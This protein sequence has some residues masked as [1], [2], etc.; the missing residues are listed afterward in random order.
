LGGRGGEAQ[1]ETFAGR[2]KHA[3]R[4]QI[5]P[6]LVILLE[7]LAIQGDRTFELLVQGLERVGGRP[8]ALLLRQG[9]A[10]ILGEQ[11]HSFGKGEPFIFHEE[12]NGI[13]MGVAA[14]TIID[15]LVGADRKRRRLF[16]M[17]GAAGPVV[18]PLFLQGH[19]G[20]DEAHQIAALQ[21]QVEKC[22]GK[23]DHASATPAR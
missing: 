18:L 15:L 12:T 11:G 10:G 5:I 8:L 6:R 20:I 9:Q 2:G 14:E 4:L 3:S 7:R 21:D 22:R 17:K 13:A 23:L 1:L 19:P 16:L